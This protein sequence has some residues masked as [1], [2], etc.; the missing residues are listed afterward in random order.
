MQQKITYF[1]SQKSRMRPISISLT[2]C[3]WWP[4]SVAAADDD[5][6]E[7]ESSDEDKVESDVGGWLKPVARIIRN[8]TAHTTEKQ[9]KNHI[10]NCL[11]PQWLLVWS[12]Y[13]FNCHCHCISNLPTSIRVLS[14][15]HS[16]RLTMGQKESYGSW[17]AATE[18][19]SDWDQTE[20]HYLQT[21]QAIT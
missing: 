2:R 9:L 3:W 12:N 13:K 4:K 6:A 1:F 17:F 16:H 8:W 14:R 21:S 5:V 10:S 15:R 18:Q 19:H 11:S 7:A 20:K